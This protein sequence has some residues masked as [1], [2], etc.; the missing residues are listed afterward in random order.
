MNTLFP[1]ASFFVEKLAKREAQAVQ[2]NNHKQAE[3]D[4]GCPRQL[5]HAFEG[6]L[7]CFEFV[8][9]LFVILWVCCIPFSWDLVGFRLAPLVDQIYVCT[10][11]RLPN[12]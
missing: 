11:C 3:Y 8:F 9:G 7:F 12:D 1:D 5:L 4:A 2:K 10:F 6:L